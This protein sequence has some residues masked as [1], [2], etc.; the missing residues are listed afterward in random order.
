MKKHFVIIILLL[1]AIGGYGQTAGVRRVLNENTVVVD[2]AG[3]KYAYADW[4][5]MTGSGDY[6]LR[7][8]EPIID[9]KPNSDPN[10]EFTLVPFTAEMKAK[11]KSRMGPPPASPF[12]TTGEKIEPFRV[13]D[14]KGNKID[15]K[16]WAGKTVVLN[17][18]FIDCAPCRQ[19]MP[20]LNKIVA[21]Y[22]GNP[23]VIFIGV[24]L[25][26]QYEVK[27]FTKKT[28]FDY[29]LVGEGRQYAQMFGI[30][31]YPTNVVVDKEGNVLFHATGYSLNTADW[32]EK[33]IAKSEAAKPTVQ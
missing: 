21:K 14:I 16:D 20:E 6:T 27:D 24:A 22:A 29:H 7:L 23:N 25:D 15:T 13:K 4:K 18:W 3:K 11:Q 19:E 30:K 33:S 28:P 5:K 17:F 10:A 1:A 12:F 32:V 2:S 8:K 9:G 31:S 26:E